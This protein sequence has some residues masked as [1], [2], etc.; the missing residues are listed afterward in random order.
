MLLG[1]DGAGLGRNSLWSGA[2][3]ETSS[4]CS[5]ALSMETLVLGRIATAAV[6]LLKIFGLLF[7]RPAK[8]LKYTWIWNG[9]KLEVGTVLRIYEQVK[10]YPIN[11]GQANIVDDYHSCPLYKPR[12]PCSGICSHCPNW[13]KSAVSSKKN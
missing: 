3:T 8:C 4:T 11:G 9:M 7:F 1:A 10:Y 5:V 2:L 12:K 13:T 6:A